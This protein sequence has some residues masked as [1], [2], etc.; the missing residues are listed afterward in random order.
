MPGDPV[1]RPDAMAHLP[2]TRA[3]VPEEPSANP[4]HPLGVRQIQ[5]PRVQALTTAP[6]THATLAP[7]GG[8][9]RGTIGCHLG[10]APRAFRPMIARRDRFESIGLQEGSSV[11]PECL[12]GG[13]GSGDPSSVAP[14]PMPAIKKR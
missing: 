10:T 5:P 14:E 2:A 13:N 3:L 8:A 1:E 6:R 7:D 12:A 9:E 4:L 11:L